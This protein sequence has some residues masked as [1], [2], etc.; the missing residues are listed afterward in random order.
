MRKYTVPFP[1]LKEVTEIVDLF[2]ITPATNRPIEIYGMRFQQNT[3]LG[4]EQSEIL[5]GKVSRGWTTSGSGGASVT[6]KPQDAR[7][8]A[9][10]FA[11]EIVNTTVAKEGT[12]EIID[13]FGFHVATG[14]ELWLPEGSGWRCDAGQTRLTV[15]LLAKPADALKLVGNL[16]VAEL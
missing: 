1:E 2:E 9:A 16:Y 3:E 14:C 15:R 4:D 5:V 6:P 8:V 12:E 10:G 7:D 13:D 11:A